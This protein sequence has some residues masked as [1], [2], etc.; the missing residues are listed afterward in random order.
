MLTTKAL[1][2]VKDALEAL[3]DY[4]YK[5]YIDRKG[6]HHG[7]RLVQDLTEA[8]LS[9]KSTKWLLDEHGEVTHVLLPPGL[10]G[11]KYLAT[12]FKLS[13]M[14]ENALA[15]RPIDDHEQGDV[16]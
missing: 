7:I 1:G 12:I 4:G 2:R 6:E 14:I 5:G 11:P 9:Y 13:N 15:G 10:V 8:Y 3:Q 16:D